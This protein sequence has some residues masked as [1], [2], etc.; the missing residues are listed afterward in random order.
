MEDMVMENNELKENIRKKVKEKIAVSNITE[1]FD[2]NK[3]DNKK[4]LYTISS[5]CAVFVLCIGIA[6][7]M[8]LQGNTNNDIQIAAKNDTNKYVEEL[9]SNIHEEKEDSIIFNSGTIK[10]SVDVDGKFEE[11]ELRQEFDF[12][13][14]IVIPGNVKL[15]RQGKMFVKPNAESVEYSKLRQY[16]LMYYEETDK[17]PSF[18]EI[19]FTTENEVL[20]CML[21]DETDMKSSIMNGKEVKL[22]KEEYL[23]DRSKIV[24][25]AFFEISGYKFFVE[26]HK[27][28][29][30]EFLETVKSVLNLPIINTK[31]D[32]DIGVQEQPSEVL[33]KNY[34]ECYGGKYI[35]NNGNNVVWICEDNQANRTEICKYLGI[36]ENKTIFKVAKYSYNYLEDLQNKI[37]KKMSNKE[38]PFVT[39]S[40][41]MEATN[42]IKVTVT[43]NKEEDLKKLKKLDSIGGAMEIQYNEKAMQK[44]EL[45]REKD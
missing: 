39:T 37:S 35:D 20:G 14:K 4:I 21:P 44:N 19:T 8:K 23:E 15:V 13:D 36:A 17:D 5:I 24:G 12:I 43:S 16:V 42:N 30:N 3:T 9:G 25:N 27:T 32:K 40:T 38:I 7:N 29:E 45:L 28:D 2:R 11:I 18:I 26:A 34:P 31:S 22:C 6:V 41:L 10:S 1:E 33:N